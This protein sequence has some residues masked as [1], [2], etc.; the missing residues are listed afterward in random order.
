VI[1]VETPR[2]RALEALESLG[3]E[4]GVADHV[5]AV[6][7]AEDWQAEAVAMLAEAVAALLIE[8]RPKTGAAAR[9]GAER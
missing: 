9:K 5:R 8:I 3:R 7:R 2:R 4:Y 6:E 1:D